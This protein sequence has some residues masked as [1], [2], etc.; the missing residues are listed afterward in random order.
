MCF[1]PWQYACWLRSWWLDYVRHSERS[2]DT[3]TT[4]LDGMPTQP[5]E[6]WQ[7]PPSNVIQIDRTPTMPQKRKR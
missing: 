3:D 1:N 7:L 4:T 2:E 5:L 6:T